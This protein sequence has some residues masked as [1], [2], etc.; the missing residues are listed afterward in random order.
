MHMHAQSFRQL[1]SDILPRTWRTSGARHGMRTRTRTRHPR[2]TYCLA[3]LRVERA[4]WARYTAPH[5]CDERRRAV[6]ARRALDTR[7]SVGV[8]PLLAARGVHTHVVGSGGGATKRCPHAAIQHVEDAYTW[9]TSQRFDNELRGAT[10]AVAASH[11]RV[12]ISLLPLR[13]RQYICTV[14][15]GL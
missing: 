2:A 4:G 12:P 1:C 5:A 13:A 10:D 14:T 15:L 7:C 3:C 9:G 11:V 8:P 6:G